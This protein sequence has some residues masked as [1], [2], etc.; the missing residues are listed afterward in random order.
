ML[1]GDAIRVGASY[2]VT[3]ARCK[4]AS[5]ALLLSTGHCSSSIHSS[6]LHSRP[7]LRS[8]SLPLM[9]SISRQQ[10]Y[11]TGSDSRVGSSSAGAGGESESTF[12]ARARYDHQHDNESYLRFRRG[13]IIKVLT[14]LDSGWWDGLLKDK[15][16]RFP[17]NYVTVISQ[18]KTE[19]ALHPIL[20]L[21]GVSESNWGHRSSAMVS[22]HLR[23][24]AT[25]SARRE[26][27][28]QL[29]GEQAAR[30]VNVIQLVWELV[31]LICST[32]NFFPSGF[33]P[34]IFGIAYGKK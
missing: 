16:G 30:V 17:S 32:I 22:I 6:P 2:M 26:A 23:E 19:T 21:L 10:S 5:F 20:G 4:D 31:Q 14:R 18:Q 15:R 29:Q 13:D 33:L 34:T 8:C 7:H 25:I 9:A 3:S 12:F 24:I 1:Y 28:L 27:L 11:G